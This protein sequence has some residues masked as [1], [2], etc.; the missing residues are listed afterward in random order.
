MLKALPTW[1][2]AAVITAGQTAVAALLLVLLDV[3]FDVQDW[4][5]DPTNPVDLSGAAT[6]AGVV[7]IT[8]LSGVVTAVVRAVKPPENTYP[9]PPKPEAV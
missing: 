2:R 7:V 8:F 5:E 4:V 6:A 1:L 9:E 3:L